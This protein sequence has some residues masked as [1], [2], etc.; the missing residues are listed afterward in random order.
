MLTR[1]GEPLSFGTGARVLKRIL[2]AERVVARM[3]D[4]FR[5][6]GCGV[7]RFARLLWFA[8]GSHLLA[9]PREHDFYK[10]FLSQAFPFAL[11]VARAFG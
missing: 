6:E 11:Q 7:R 1:C 9:L 4:G 5:L 10:G 2:L 3:V 8:G